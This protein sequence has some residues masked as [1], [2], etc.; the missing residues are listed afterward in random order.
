MNTNGNSSFGKTSNALWKERL[1]DVIDDRLRDEIDQ[2]ETTID[3][4]T[5]GKVD[6]KLFAETRLRRGAYGQRYD[7]GQRYDGKQTRTLPY[8]EHETKGPHT[9]WDAP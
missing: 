9:M 8:D 6:E 7:N 1:S 4:R 2:F 5:Q 3:L